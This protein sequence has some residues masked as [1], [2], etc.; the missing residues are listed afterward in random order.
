MGT[1][2]T[3]KQFAAQVEHWYRRYTASPHFQQYKNLEAG[4]SQKASDVGYLEKGD[5][6]W[7]A[8]WGGDE[9]RHQLGTLICNN[10]TSENVVRHT[11]EAIEKLDRPANAPKSLICISYVGPAYGSKALRC[12]CPQKHAAFDYHVRKACKNLLPEM[13]DRETEVAGYVWFLELCTRLLESVAVPGPRPGGVW[14]IADI[15]MALFQFAFEGG[16]LL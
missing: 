11:K 4:L 2:L 13:H 7:I 15:E 3:L 1:E 10:N 5:L 16:I 8:I 14:Y 12:I 9:K 6:L